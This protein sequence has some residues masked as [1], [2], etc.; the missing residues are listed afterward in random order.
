MIEK[1]RKF[2]LQIDNFS[3]LR[4]EKLSSLQDKN[5]TFPAKASIF[6]IK[7]KIE[8]N[9]YR[10]W[11]LNW[12]EREASSII[13]GQCSI[14]CK[15]RQAIVRWRKINHHSCETLVENSRKKRV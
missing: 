3:M 14:E 4:L 11:V 9:F 7:H 13:F 1:S 6:F 5:S 2:I 12:R 15:A 8:L 10:Y